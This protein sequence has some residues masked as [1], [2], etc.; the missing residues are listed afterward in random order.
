MDRETVDVYEARATDWVAR[1]RRPTPSSLT[2]F[3]R[4]LAPDA[5]TLD[6]GC[7]PGWHTSALGDRA[8]ACDAARAMLDLVPE[9]APGAWRVLADLETL[10]FRREV[11][12]GTWAHKCYM[13]IPAARV[14]LALAELHRASRVGS[15]AHIHVTSDRLGPSFDDPF[16]GR[17][18]EYWSLDGLVDLVEGAGF[19]VDSVHDDGKEWIDVEA[20][21]ARELPDTVGPG[22]RVLLVGLNPSEY[23]A[24]AGVG[25][26]R[27]GNRFWPAAL[28]S[29]LVT[30]THDAFRAFRV[31]RVGMTDLVKRATVRAD[32]VTREEYRRGA[33]RVERLVEWLRPEAVCFVGLAGYRAARDRNATV[34]WQ[35]RPYGGRPA[36]VMPNPSGLNAHT[37]P[38]D[39]VAHLRAIREA[40]AS[41]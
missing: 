29:G 21:R 35:N 33:D 39:F 20:T 10:P 27:P 14:P 26:A 28:E 7:G 34:G 23:A 24:D 1:R 16:A 19:T 6:L 8:V 3:A 12:G 40:A 4:R 15:P 38:A 31:D 2:A 9:H 36:Y 17:H 13:H 5:V 37:R 18:F 22:M 30:A 32:A 41:T 25:F 11:L